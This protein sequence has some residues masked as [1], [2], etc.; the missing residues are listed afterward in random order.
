LT[1]RR[2]VYQMPGEAPLSAQIPARLQDGGQLSFSVP[3]EVLASV[4]D[5]A[6]LKRLIPRP[7]WLTVRF[8]RMLVRTSTGEFVSAPLDKE[9]RKWFLAFAEGT[10]Q[11]EKLEHGS[12]S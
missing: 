7:R 12:D 6:F 5:S 3:V 2:Y 11:G 1:L 9:L 10:R 8:L 4:N